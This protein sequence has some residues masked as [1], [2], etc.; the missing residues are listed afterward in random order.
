[1]GRWW[2][3]SMSLLGS[4]CA[5]DPGGARET[6]DIAPVDPVRW[7]IASSLAPVADEL[8]GRF[9]ISTGVDVRVNLASSSVLAR[10][11]VHGA[12]V[13]V[14][15]SA[16]RSWVDHVENETSV[17]AR[18]TPWATNRV[19]WV[20]AADAPGG[21]PPS[22]EPD[23]RVALGDPEHVPLGR[24]AKAWLES[25]GYWEALRPH[26]VY[27]PHARAALAFV[28]SGAARYGA[29]YRTDARASTGV[30]EVTGAGQSAKT[31]YWLVAFPA[32]TPTVADFEA[33]L[34]GQE[35]DSILASAGFGHPEGEDS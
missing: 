7:F 8:A 4:G 25:L 2:L 35:A 23:D 17:S 19:V 14:W 15:I 9:R 34:A 29:V 24:A 6:S 16:D 3:L 27:A 33:F 30:R 1:M 18:V 31:T 5:D 10:Q 11:I 22:L 13:D 20:R 12:P 32:D 26:V 28:E 21:W